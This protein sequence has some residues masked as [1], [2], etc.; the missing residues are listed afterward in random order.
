MCRLCLCDVIGA[1][2]QLGPV[3]VVPEQETV[4]AERAGEVSADGWLMHLIMVQSEV[5]M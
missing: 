4:A 3:V 1:H 5:K 2:S